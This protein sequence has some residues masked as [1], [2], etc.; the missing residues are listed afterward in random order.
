ML[1]ILITAHNEGDEVRKTVDS[2]LSRT[3]GHVE[4][5]VV[6]DGSTD[7]CC[8]QLDG[9]Q[10]RVLRNAS[11]TG[12]APSRNQAVQHASGD[13]FAFLDGHQRVTSGALNRCA[14]FAKDRSAILF[15]DNRS[16]RGGSVVSHGATFELC[17][18]HGYF[19][20][21]WNHEAPRSL[22][23]RITSLRAPAYVIPRSVWD[24]VHWIHGLRSWGGSEAAVSL[25]AFFSDVPIL[26]LCGTLTYH[27]YKKELHYDATWE[28][29]WRNH[30]L[31]ARVCFDDRTWQRYWLPQVF[32][33]HLPEAARRELDSDLVLRQHEEFCRHKVR[34]DD[35]FWTA[36]LQQPVPRELL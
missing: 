34:R 22:L 10:V 26:H 15:P 7:H 8:D 17:P 20:A 19:S 3:G 24:Q 2:V 28:D 1:S 31:I 18:E 35:E 27:R 6:D 25:K 16:F 32:A 23:T 13:A 9:K 30:A 33:D 29:V 12:V 36:L 11:R 4:V 14:A 5:V 21:S